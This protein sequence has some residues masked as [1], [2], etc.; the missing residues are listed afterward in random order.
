MRRTPDVDLQNDD[1]VTITVFGYAAANPDDHIYGC[2]EQRS[3]FDLRGKPL[4]LWT[5]EQALAVQKPAMSPAGR[6]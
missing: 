2:G 1:L 3:Y 4:P 6:L 5:S